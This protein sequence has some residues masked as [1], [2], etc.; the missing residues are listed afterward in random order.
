M[1]T[2]L[3]LRTSTRVAADQ[4]ISTYP[5]DVAVNDIIDRH[6]R[7][8]WRRMIAVGWK[9]TRTTVSITANGATSYPLGT[10]VSTVNS[11]QYLGTPG[12]NTFRQV[13]NRVKPE[14]L[15]DLLSSPPGTPAVA[16]DLI[17]GGTSTMTIE[18]YPVPSAGS[19][20]VRYTP[21]FPGFAADADPWFGPDGSEE[22]IILASA[23]EC[24][25]KEGDPSD[26]V[27]ALQRRLTERWA[28]VIEAAGWA[29]SMGQQTVR[30]S[31][32]KNRLPFDFQGREG[33]DGDF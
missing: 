16:Y 26:L 3:Q 33:W 8:V 21:R 5:T 4:D 15:A 17:G 20:E 30:D 28:D 24:A 11:V 23:I 14:D 18:L 6:A 13:L 22:L 29:D 2:R 19:Y 31:R 1:T 25:N 27:A 10:D 12:S 32:R 9:P 7:A